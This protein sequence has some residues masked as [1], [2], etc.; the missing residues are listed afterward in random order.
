MVLQ[1]VTEAVAILFLA[2]GLLVQEW[3]WVAVGGVVFAGSLYFH[4]IS[5][6]IQIEAQIKVRSARANEDLR[7]GAD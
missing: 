5:A 4:L 7:E 3:P 1:Y 2:S 6:L